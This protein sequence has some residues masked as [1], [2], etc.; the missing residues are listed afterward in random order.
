MTWNFHVE[1]SHGNPRYDMILGRDI[2]SN[3]KIDLRFYDNN[4]RRNEGAYEGC[5]EPMKDA[6]KINF[7]YLSDWI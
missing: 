3:L 5:T 6:L 4:I 2:L 1:D 7:N